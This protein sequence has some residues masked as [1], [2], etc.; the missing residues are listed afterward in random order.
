MLLTDGSGLYS[1]IQNHYFLDGS[2]EIE[3]INSTNMGIGFVIK[4]VDLNITIRLY[5]GAS[6]LNTQPL[7][8]WSDKEINSIAQEI[9]AYHLSKCSLKDLT[10]WVKEQRAN[11]AYRSEYDTKQKIREALG[12]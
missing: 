2:I 9:L 3:K 5:K 6:I 7:E 11:A 4:Y 10:N 12:L 1:V 8:K